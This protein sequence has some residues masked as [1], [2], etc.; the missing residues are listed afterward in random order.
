[1]SDDIEYNEVRKLMAD[2]QARNRK[3]MRFA[4]LVAALIAL[5][6]WNTQWPAIRPG[7]CVL[8][9]GQIALAGF[10][11]F[12]NR[13]LRAPVSAAEWL[14]S[15]ASAKRR[16]IW[17]EQGSRGLG[18]MLLAFGFWRSTGS[19][20]VSVALGLVYPLVSFWGSRRSA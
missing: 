10:L 2:S 18:F 4:L 12:R 11:F 5:L 8:L 1:V 19:V 7:L 20:I 13:R 9:A 15:D 14:D 17:L 3:R 6:L 16:A